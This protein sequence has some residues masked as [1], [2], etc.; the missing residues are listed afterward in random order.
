MAAARAFGR[1][2]RDSGGCRGEIVWDGAAC[3]AVCHVHDFHGN[4]HGRL[5]DADADMES[6]ERMMFDQR[7]VKGKRHVRGRFE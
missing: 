2:N 6:H 7:K 4:V 3:W 1:W 5:E